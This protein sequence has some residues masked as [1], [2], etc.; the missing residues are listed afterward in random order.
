MA[1]E[2]NTSTQDITIG[3]IGG[4]GWLG[5]A[6]V[7][8]ALAN[9]RLNDIRFIVSGRTAPSSVLP[10][11]VTYT[12]DN[13]A[14]IESS[15]LIVLSVRPQD[16]QNIA[17]DLTSKPV[18]S[19]M[20][21][22]PCNELAQRHNPSHIIRALPNG[23]C[24]VK[25]SYTPWFCATELDA[26][27]TTLVIAL[28]ESFGYQD[29]YD[30]EDQIDV[31]TAISGA[32]PGYPAL[33]AQALEQAAV[34]MGLPTD[35]ARKAVNATIRGSGYL[36]DDL[37]QPPQDMVDLLESYQGTTAAGLSQMKQQGFIE[38]VEAGVLAAYNKAKK[39]S[40]PQ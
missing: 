4:L 12:S 11:S 10:D 31:L 21:G 27:L 13:Q 33:L 19:F 22:A 24:S 26:T 7:T 29:R 38:S 34:S 6:L 16:W 8:A 14:L 17:L 32:G 23:A 2:H 3:V 5:S 18:I 37:N 9:P 28:L 40:E 39:F 1:I 20:A 36:V 15:D 35:K 30:T 25:Q